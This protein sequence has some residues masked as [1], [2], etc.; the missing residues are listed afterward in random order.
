[1]FLAVGMDTFRS[2]GLIVRARR[3]LHAGE[4]VPKPAMVG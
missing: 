2:I 1:M 4:R 3:A